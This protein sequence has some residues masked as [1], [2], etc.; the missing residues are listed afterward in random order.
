M[1]ALCRNQAGAKVHAPCIV[2]LATGEVSELSVYDPHPTEIGEVTAA[3]KKGYT[4]FF[5][6]AGA[7]IQQNPD[8]EYCEA[9]LPRKEEPIEPGHFCYE[10][11]RILTEPDRNGYVIADMYNPEAVEVYTVWDGAK[12][13]IRDYLVTVNRTDS[14]ALEIEVHGLLDEHTSQNQ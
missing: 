14:G 8:L 9:T 11:R 2:N 10:C 6:G 4:S 13:E 12:Y 3:P 7:M 5:T 1:C